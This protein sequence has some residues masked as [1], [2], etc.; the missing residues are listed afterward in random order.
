MDLSKWHSGE[1][2]FAAQ[3]AALFDKKQPNSNHY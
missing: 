1:E 2:P 3:T